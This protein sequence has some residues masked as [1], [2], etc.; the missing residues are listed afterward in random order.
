VM[1]PLDRLL[2]QALIDRLS[3]SFIGSSA[4]WLYGW[5]L[6]R[7]MPERGRYIR[8]DFEWAGYRDHLTRLASWDECALRT[9][10]VS[11]FASVLSN[12]LRNK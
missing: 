2:Y 7:D 12:W 11:F 8:N 3:V 10:V 5:R 9:D 1:D 6:D 4:G